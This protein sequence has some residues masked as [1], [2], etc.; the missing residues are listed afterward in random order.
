[1]IEGN[2]TQIHQV[3]INLCINARDAMPQ[4]GRLTL[5][6]SNLRVD[7]SYIQLNVD[8]H[9]GPYVQ[10]TVTDTGVGMGAETR[11][12]IFT[13]FFTTKGAEGGTGLGLSTVAG[14]VKEQ[15]GFIN[16]SSKQG[17]GTEFQVFLPAIKTGTAPEALDPLIS[18]GKGKL[19]LVVDDEAAIRAI[20]QASLEAYGYGVITAQDGIEAIALFAKHSANINAILI[21]MMMP[22]MDGETAILTLQR[23]APEVQIIAMSGL[24]FYQ[25]SQDFIEKHAVA[26]IL[27]KPYTTKKLLETLQA[28]LSI[29][30]S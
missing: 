6:A 8:A 14:I 28:V 21:G 17:R 20:T 22:I 29:A 25:N 19:I 12:K 11:T 26:A 23:M 2:A 9:V 10:V 30:P 27:N 4:G 24:A 13:P 7:E 5:N 1:M 15:G 18:S 16:V 3:L